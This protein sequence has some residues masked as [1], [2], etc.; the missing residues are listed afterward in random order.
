MTY[1]ERKIQKQN[2][3]NTIV[4]TKRKINMVGINCPKIIKS[5]E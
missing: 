5:K 4:K 2:T 1:Q 3:P